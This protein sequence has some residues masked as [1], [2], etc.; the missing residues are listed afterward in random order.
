[1]S[2]IKEPKHL[3]LKRKSKKVKKSYNLLDFVVVKKKNR[4]TQQVTRVKV[5]KQIVKRG[6]SRKKKVTTIKKR[7]LKERKAKQ[8]AL[9]SESLNKQLNSYVNVDNVIEKLTQ[10]KIKENILTTLAI[11]E[12]CSSASE[13][14]LQ[15]NQSLNVVVPLTS[16]IV[17][18]QHSRNFRDYCDHMITQ[19]IKQL[20]EIVLKDL[21]KFQENKFNQNPSNNLNS[22]E[23][24]KIHGLIVFQLRR[25]L[26]NATSL[27]SRR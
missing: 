11:E 5:S 20:T 13:S 25:K 8:L 15:P 1:M 3:E 27:D 21:F 7:I 19:E 26:T 10:I 17:P 2:E 12:N 4:K 6:K 18:V 16:N 24:L 22:F 23:S 9:L 14:S